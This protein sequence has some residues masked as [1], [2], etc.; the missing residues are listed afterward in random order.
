MTDYTKYLENG[1]EQSE[2]LN[3]DSNYVIVSYFWGRGNVN[4]NSIRKLTYDQ[5]VDRLIGNCRKLKLNYCFIEYPIFAETKQYQ[6]AIGLKGVFIAKCLEKF[7]KTVVYI[8]TDLQIV[9]T[10]TIF[11]IDADVFFLNWNEYQLNCY[12]P[13]QVELPGGIMAFGNTF[14][15]KALLK[16]LNDYMLKHLH[17]VEDKSFSGIVSRHMM[18]TYL[19]CV[20]IPAN[21]LY[22]YTTH[23]YD[24]K[25][26]TYSHIATLKQDVKETG[27]YKEKD[28]VFIHEDLETADLGDVYKQRISKNRWP[29]N[30]YNQIGEKLRCEQIKYLNYTDFNMNKEQ[31][32]HYQTDLKLKEKEGIIKNVTI[33]KLQKLNTKIN[34]H[35]QSIND[36]GPIIVSLYDETTSSETVELFIS[37]C[38]KFNLNYV[39]YHT[40]DKSK[41]NKPIL[42][43]KLLTKY[44]TNI[45]Y[46][47]INYKIKKQPVLFNVKNIDFMTVNLDNT[48]IDGYLCSDIRIL[49]TINDNLYFFAYNKVCLQFLQI[50]AGFNTKLKYQHKNLE[51][52]F[53]VSV[54]INKLRCF[55]F[56]KDYILGPILSFPKELKSTL[57][58]NSYSNSKHRTLTKSLQQCGL[59]PKLNDGEPVRAHY[60]GSVNGSIYHNRY[61]KL[62]LE[63]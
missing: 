13:Y 60:H 41:I 56:P 30:F 1:I 9:K 27:E 45:C 11:D 47:D 43:H 10:P 3:P 39:V 22:M 29:K 55:W 57:F 26:G 17:L 28:I 8:D 21:Y 61:G 32:N 38:V 4:K 24:E 59:K 2:M 42:F 33:P 18:N 25:T 6:L 63:F 5:Q 40:K 53:N 37:N 36:M 14:G 19:R 12:N 20:W 34:K 15:A 50:W 54:A 31:L 49:R 62:F 23:E 46:L 44:K 48:S 52:A 51:Y 16:I 7:G 58:N 35:Y